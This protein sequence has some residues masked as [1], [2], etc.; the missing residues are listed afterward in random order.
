MPCLIEISAHNKLAQQSF[1]YVE[2]IKEIPCILIAKKEQRELEQIFYQNT[3]GIGRHFYFVESADDARLSVIG[4]RG[5]LTVADI[6]LDDDPPGLKR[7]PLLRK[8][9]TPIGLNYC[10]FWKKEKKITE[11][12]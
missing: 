2:E 7:L 4:N 12:K 10:A 9:H 1:A 11:E 8:D 6:G 5:F 3:L